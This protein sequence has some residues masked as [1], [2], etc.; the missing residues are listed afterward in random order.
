MTHLTKWNFLKNSTVWEASIKISNI[1]TLK[2]EYI[3]INNMKLDQTILYDIMANPQDTFNYLVNFDSFVTYPCNDN[4]PTHKEDEHKLIFKKSDG[5]LIDLGVN[6]I[7]KGKCPPPANFLPPKYY[8]DENLI[9]QNDLASNLELIN[10]ETNIDTTTFDMKIDI[11]NINFDI[12]EF[13]S[14]LIV[15]PRDETKSLEVLFIKIDSNYSGTN[16]TQSLT[17]SGLSKGNYYAIVPWDYLDNP[18]NSLAYY[19]NKFDNYCIQKIADI[20]IE[21]NSF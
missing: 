21:N 20:K 4:E 17:I 9:D 8:I 3:E 6:V 12:K 2:V 14:Q 1:T 16:P 19:Q 7:K 13:N 11:N 5:T 10:M 18:T 15:D